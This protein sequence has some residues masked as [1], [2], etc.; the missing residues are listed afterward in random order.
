MINKIDINKFGL[1]SGYQWDKSI[2]K[3]FTFK[4]LNIIFGRNYSGKT[5]ISR[6]L[7][8]LEDKA[9][10]PNYLNSEFTF[11]LSDNSKIVSSNLAE[12]SNNFIFR[13]YNTDFVKTN[14]SWLRNDD[15]TIE[16]FTILGVK[17]VE[18]DN[19]IKEI[20]NKLGSVIDK[21]GLL[22]DFDEKTKLLNEKNKSFSSIQ[23]SIEGKLKN[24][25]N[26]QI[27]LNPNLFLP[28]PLKKT[29][30]IN[31]IKNE[32]EVILSDI[33]KYVL[34]ENETEDYKKLLKEQPK[35]EITEKIIE[36]KPN[37]ENYLIKVKEITTIEIKP[38][39][40]I[41]D[42]IN[43][44]LLQKWVREGIEKH[45]GIRSKCA[46]CGNDLPVDIWEKLDSHF[47]KESEDLRELILSL[48]DTLNKAKKSITTFLKINKETFYSSLHKQFEE[49]LNQWNL[50]IVVYLTNL[51][52][53]I[54][55]L[56][57]RLDDIFKPFEIEEFIDNSD[58]IVGIIKEF[59]RLIDLNNSKTNTLDG[60]QQNAR[61]K[62]R[63]SVIAEFIKEIDYE[64]N[65]L[66]LKEAEK[67]VKEI[68]TENKTL[69]NDINLLNETKKSLEREAKDE[70]RGAELINQHLT[71][72]FGHD[73]LKLVA[74]G[75]TPNLKFKITRVSEDAK[76]LS[77]G[78]CSLIS[79][80]Y[81]IAKMED[82]MSDEQNRGKLII[83]IDD[84]ISSLDSNHIFFMYS[85]IDTVIAKP[86]KYGQ[87]FISTHNLDFLKF[88]KRIT[89]PDNDKSNIAYFLIERRRKQNETISTFID[90][91]SHI[92]DYVTEFNFLFNEI[93]KVHKQCSGSKKMMIENTYNQFY[94]LP[95][96]I[97]KF[98]ECY[99]FYKYPNTNDPLANLNK[100]FDN[101][102]PCLIN[103]VIN[104]YS[105]LT[106]IDRGWKP[107]DV[108]EAEECAT[109][110]V[111]KIQE[112][113]PDQYEALLQSIR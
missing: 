57:N 14:L 11:Y 50:A 5:T 61:K 12:N 18:L 1:F 112:K 34:S 82:E 41:L 106:Y 26:D 70:S 68:E 44:A 66:S 3:D 55:R 16:P 90:M 37:F 100:L 107:I 91:P 24:K 99:L 35:P 53:L 40:P 101:H 49:L 28:T 110:I 36:S 88:L 81:F 10:H 98:L 105:H 80:C 4:K 63:Y 42:L 48:I 94:N 13:V 21:R 52:K 67:A 54:D 6:I 8:C 58:I 46:F 78:E 104:E 59:N 71:N 102:V 109:I 95:N 65:V 85:L 20:E 31:D 69:F 25:A 32:I 22:Y 108:D 76:N 51:D 113:D 30:Q 47:S 92:K 79:F 75:E 29:Y 77:E 7:K 96:N 23:S 19:K 56:T 27:K 84:P 17:N 73:E 62:L 103:R 93:Y 72:Y 43:D 87:L 86:K 2:G 64:K 111:N 15:G 9:I 45:K 83:Y 60:E 89:I 39:K 38:N 33:N 74:F 97:R